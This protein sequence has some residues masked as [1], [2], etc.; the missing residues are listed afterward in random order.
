MLALLA[1]ALVFGRAEWGRGG[2]SAGPIRSLVVLPLE[3]VGPG[4]AQG[5]DYFAEG[6]TDAL[7]TDLA[8]IRALDVISRTSALRY[9]GRKV[10]MSQISRE[11]NVDAV[12]EG[13]VARLGERVRR[14]DRREP[15]RIAERR[16]E[17][18]I[19]D[20]DDRAAAKSGAEEYRSIDAR[21]PGECLRKWPST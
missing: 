5:Q 2:L 3:S 6:I 10:P 16:R 1:A 8:Q 19:P 4:L 7:T 13:T 15:S 21:L 18:T 20:L 9:R 12:V 11:L 14:N 17:T